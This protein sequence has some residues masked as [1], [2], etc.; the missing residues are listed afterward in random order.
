[1]S[2]KILALSNLMK[3]LSSGIRIL[4]DFRLTDCTSSTNI[5][6]HKRKFYDDVGDFPFVKRLFASV[7]EPQNRSLDISN[8]KNEVLGKRQATNAAVSTPLAPSLSNRKRPADNIDDNGNT[9]QKRV[10]W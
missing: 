8:G 5:P 4:V 10:R 6:S 3:Y 7:R 1:M 9:P 2:D